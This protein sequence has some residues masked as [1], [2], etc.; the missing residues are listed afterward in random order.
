MPREDLWGLYAVSNAYL[1]T[2][3]AEGLGLPV[4]DAMA[5]GIPVVATDTGALHELLEDDRGFLIPPEYKIRA[6]VWGNSTRD[7]I[8]VN[9]AASVLSE[10]AVHDT[11]VHQEALKYIQKRTWEVA[12]NQVD[13]K[14]KELTHAAEQQQE[15]NH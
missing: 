1:C 13:R 15:A 2:S 7:M 10:L 6:D 8:D 5:A 3:K 12:I 11:D 14:I 9:L 4:L